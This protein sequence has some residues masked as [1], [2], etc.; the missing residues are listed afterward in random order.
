MYLLS[1]RLCNWLQYI[2]LLLI[3][4]LGLL[5]IGCT[6]H[7]LV[8]QKLTD[9]LEV[10]IKVWES[11]QSTLL[12]GYMD[13]Q[14]FGNWTLSLVT[15]GL[16]PNWSLFWSLFWTRPL[17]IS[18]V[19]IKKCCSMILAVDKQDL[20]LQCAVCKEPKQTFLSVCKGTR[21]HSAVCFFLW[22]WYI[23]GLPC[24]FVLY[25]ECCVLSLGLVNRLYSEAGILS[26][27]LK[28]RLPSNSP[29]LHLSQAYSGR[30]DWQVSYMID[31]QEK[32]VMLTPVV[33]HA[34]E[35]HGISV[36][37]STSFCGLPSV[38]PLPC[39]VLD[40]F[41]Y[42][43]VLA[44]VGSF[45]PLF[46]VEELT[47]SCW[48]TDGVQAASRTCNVKVRNSVNFGHANSCK[49]GNRQR[50]V[51]QAKRF[52]EV[53]WT[54]YQDIALFDTALFVFR[55]WFTP[56]IENKTLHFVG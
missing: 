29:Q 8:V 49:A 51:R 11:A 43:L 23:S 24:K 14:M 10:G 46:F 22:L 1:F 32:A 5:F 30:H 19:L 50:I 6:L 20:Q 16:L 45:R 40:L 33:R 15:L 36:K 37:L 39:P 18:Q 34:P 13:S 17:W 53:A 42:C 31:Q 9:P 55:P 54:V 4:P 2:L 25:C 3:S 47:C 27:T 52:S 56:L 41:Q 28:K 48:N 21:T 7:T 38:R 12:L 35:D 44:V 26:V